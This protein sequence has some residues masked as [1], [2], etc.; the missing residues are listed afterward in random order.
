MCKRGER[1]FTTHH[2]YYR[3]DAQSVWE[4]AG[5]EGRVMSPWVG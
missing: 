2:D 5:T 4:R 1:S 3:L